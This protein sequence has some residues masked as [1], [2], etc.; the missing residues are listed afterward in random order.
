MREV[1]FFA[2]E[3]VVCI[4]VK[5]EQIADSKLNFTIVQA[6]DY[7]ALVD[8]DNAES[9]YFN[10]IGNDGVVEEFSQADVIATGTMVMHYP[11]NKETPFTYMISFNAIT[12]DFFE[13]QDMYYLINTI[14]P[15]RALMF[16]TGSDM[17]DLDR[18][19]VNFNVVNE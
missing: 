10:L 5:F 11:E 6:V 18:T 4:G 9:K 7:P 12:L 1:V 15:A 19:E 17:V 16:L 8:E 13:Y 14:I 3:G 2:A